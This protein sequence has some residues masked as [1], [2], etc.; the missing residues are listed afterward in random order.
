MTETTSRVSLQLK[1]NGQP[2]VVDSLSCNHSVSDLKEELFKVTRVLPKNHKFLGLRTA[3][4]DPVVD[5]TTL[6]CILLK[7]G[8]K[9]MLIGST[10]E[11]IVSFT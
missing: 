7:L 2:I 9:L 4:N 5:S 3:S 6:S 1:Y 10:Q 8:T 11:E